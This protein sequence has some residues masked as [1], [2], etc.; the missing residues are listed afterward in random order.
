MTH[1]VSPHLQHGIAA[2]RDRDRLQFALVDDCH[3]G[4]AGMVLLRQMREPLGRGELFKAAVGRRS[5]S[6]HPRQHRERGTAVKAL[7]GRSQSSRLAGSRPDARRLAVPAAAPAPRRKWSRKA[8][9]CAPLRW[10]RRVTAPNG[11]AKLDRWGDRT[12][13]NLEVTMQRSVRGSSQREV[14]VRGPAAPCRSPTWRRGRCV[15]QAVERQHDALGCIAM[16]VVP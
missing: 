1:A 3:C 6:C 13:G 16:E 8:G 11:G 7:Q 10:R 4:A 9:P 5:T 15:H 12:C 2:G 14:K